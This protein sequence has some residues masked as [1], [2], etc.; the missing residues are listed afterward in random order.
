M[1]R[2]CTILVN[3]KLKMEDHGCC[4]WWVHWRCEACIY[5]IYN[6]AVDVR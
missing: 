6:G 3:I 5:I 1:A 2:I 4:M